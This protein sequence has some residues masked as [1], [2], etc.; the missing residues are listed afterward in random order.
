MSGVPDPPLPFTGGR[1]PASEQERTLVERR[2]LWQFIVAPV[3]SFAALLGGFNLGWPG[4]AAVGVVG[5]GATALSI[6]GLA[7]SERRLMFIRGGTMTPREYRYFIYDGLAAVPYGMAYVVGGV[8]L[9]TVAGLFLSGA[10]PEGMRA[11]LLARPGLGL[12][13][14]GAALLFYGSG[15]VIGFVH[16]AGSPW[17]RAFGMLLDAPARLGGLILMALALAAL[18][19]GLVDL[20]S[21]AHFD[22]WFE[23]GYR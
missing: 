12:V 1:I 8:C 16:R 20:L 15:F 10:S 11:A 21:P 9:I 17:Q 7:I 13:P 22:R 6:G 19:I 5:F 14:V 18:V 3:V 2:I 4:L 23:F